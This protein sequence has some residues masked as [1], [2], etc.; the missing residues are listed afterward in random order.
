MRDL[1]PGGRAALTEIQG[2][3]NLVTVE[4]KRGDREGARGALRSVKDAFDRLEDAFVDDSL[5]KNL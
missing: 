2:F 5:R 3:L 4:L 1:A